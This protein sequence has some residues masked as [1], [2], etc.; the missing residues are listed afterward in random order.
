MSENS[1]QRWFIL[2]EGQVEGPF[3]DD[4]IDLKMKNNSA[5]SL[6]WGKGLSE[7]LTYDMWKNDRAQ[8]E[9]VKEAEKEILWS[10][11]KN[12]QASPWMP[13]TDFI[14]S[15][16]DVPETT[17]LQIA[18]DQEKVFRNLFEYPKLIEELGITRRAHPRVPI[19]GSLDAEVNG[20]AISMRVISISEGGLGV[21]EAKQL[22]L[23]QRFKAQLKS[24]NLFVAVNCQCEAVYVGQD[25]YAGIKFHNLNSEFHGAIVEYINKFADVQLK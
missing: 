14:K 18:N 20:R 16:Q 21:T 11:K 10:Y 24:P 17:E 5:E 23:G 12:D 15:I 8:F 7:W 6:V 1:P 3:V 4:D 9:E 13:L 2:L 25:G 22:S 19:M